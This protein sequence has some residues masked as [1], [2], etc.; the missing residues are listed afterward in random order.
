[1]QRRAGGEI[2]CLRPST[3][4][5]Q[6]IDG[7]LYIHFSLQARLHAASGDYPMICGGIFNHGRG[8]TMTRCETLE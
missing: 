4:L 1:M 7:V 6:H 8:T 5:Y 3:W 2:T